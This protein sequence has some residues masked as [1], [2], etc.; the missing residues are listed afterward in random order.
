MCYHPKRSACSVCA[1][2]LAGSEW[3]SC[4]AVVES[5]AYS[6]STADC[7]F[8]LSYESHYL[9]FHV[10]TCLT[11]ETCKGETLKMS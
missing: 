8:G 7:L 10:S 3:H 5:E 2:L 1:A 9:L 4:A 6:C 11:G